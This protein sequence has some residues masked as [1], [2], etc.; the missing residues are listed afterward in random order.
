MALARTGGLLTS[1]KRRRLWGWRAR[2]ARVCVGVAAYL[3]WPPWLMGLAALV[4]SRGPPTTWGSTAGSPARLVVLPHHSARRVTGPGV[5]VAR[6]NTPRTA[7]R[8]DT[9]VCVARDASALSCAAALAESCRRLAR[10]VLGNGCARHSNTFS[11]IG[12]RRI[13]AGIY[14]V[15]LEANPVAR[16]ANRRARRYSPARYAAT[17]ERI[18]VSNWGRLDARSCKTVDSHNAESTL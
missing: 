13:G 4:S 1:A 10:G 18:V 14:A 17:A 11:S 2:A 5:N 8:G 7:N 16:R 3:A 6:H 12:L 15:P 9:C